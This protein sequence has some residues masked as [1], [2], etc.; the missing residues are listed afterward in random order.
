[1]KNE[2]KLHYEIV[3]EIIDMLKE[4]Q[5]HQLYLLTDYTQFELYED[6]LCYAKDYIEAGDMIQHL[7][8]LLNERT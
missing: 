7:K 6:R 8:E 2:I 5:D 3:E 4:H 1:M